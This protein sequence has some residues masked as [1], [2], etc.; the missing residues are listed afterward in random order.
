[1]T[2]EN[3]TTEPAITGEVV[4]L[5]NRQYHS[6]PALSS[7]GFKLLARSPKH[8][9]ARYVDPNREPQEPTPAMK[10]GTAW[11]AAVFEPEEF[12]A[13][14]IALPAG[15]DRRTKEGK[16]LF[17]DVMASGKEPLAAADFDRVVAM[18]KSAREHPI[19]RVIF[20]QPG[21]KAETSLFWVD[22]ETGVQCKIRPDYMVPPCDLFPNGLI[23]DG[24][25][26]EDASADG[27]AKAIWGWAMHYQ[28]AFYTDGFQ[29]AFNTFK[30]PAFL[31]LA[32][33]KESPYACAVYSASADVVEYGRREVRRLTRLFAE[34]AANDNWPAY[35]TT[36]G[37]IELPPWAQKVINDAKQVTA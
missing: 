23:I 35:P 15:L 21:G 5:T 29:Q 11:H 13:N 26:T 6:H 27:F 19:A 36:V 18:A 14:Y 20:S 31:W 30:P 9:W 25:S 1:M 32:Q 4:G 8:Y 34:C 3:C 7:S 17:E 2:I 28:A 24:K 33:E 22:E 10:L 12:A 37:D 16:A